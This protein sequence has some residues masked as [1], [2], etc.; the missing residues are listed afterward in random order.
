MANLLLCTKCGKWVHGKLAKVKRI[1]STLAKGYNCETY[2]QAI[3]GIVESAEE[4][5]FYD[6][7]EL[8][9]SFIT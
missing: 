6:K 3:K 4:L 9:K 7:V 8:V 1:I 5:T 2:V